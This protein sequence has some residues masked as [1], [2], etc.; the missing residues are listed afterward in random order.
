MNK[1]CMICG[2]KKKILP[3]NE[4]WYRKDAIDGVVNDV[5]DNCQKQYE[6]KYPIPNFRQ[7]LN[8]FI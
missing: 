7:N 5:C 6:S 1:E 4:H 8:C 2:R 3:Q